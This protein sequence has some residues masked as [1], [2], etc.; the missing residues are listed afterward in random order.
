[1]L[2]NYLLAGLED[3]SLQQKQRLSLSDLLEQMREQ[4][5]EHDTRLLSLLLMTKDDAAIISLLEE[6]PDLH[7][8]TSLSDD[9]LKTQLL[10]EY[11]MK[12]S[13]RFVRSWFEFNLNLNNVLAATICR[14]HGFDVQ[15]AVIGNN[16]VALQLRKNS[17]ARDFGLAGILPELGDIMRLADIDNL[18]DRERHIDALRWQWLEEHT[19]FH[20]FEIEN[21]LAY[22]LQSAML[23]RWDN[24]TREEGEQVFRSLLTD[25]KKGIRFE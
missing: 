9:D 21:V 20:N 2:Y 17:S 8:E 23:H 6:N 24:L 4:L 3:I 19:V 15:K 18:L 25:L 11:G 12:S 13:N 7:E 10:Y 22:Y 16:E 5:T 1:M 14:K